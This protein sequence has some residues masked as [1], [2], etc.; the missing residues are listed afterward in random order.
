MHPMVLTKSPD[1]DVYT[2]SAIYGPQ[3]ADLHSIVIDTTS[4]YASVATTLLQPSSQDAK[5]YNKAILYP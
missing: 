5:E 3:Q 2:Q 4:K 1:S